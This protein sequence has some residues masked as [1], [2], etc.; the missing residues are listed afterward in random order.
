[1]GH[2]INTNFAANINAARDY[3][4]SKISTLIVRWVDDGSKEGKQEYMW[5]KCKDSD[6]M[7]YYKWEWYPGK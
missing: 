5:F 4:H 3:G 6:N 7:D 1:M 2:I